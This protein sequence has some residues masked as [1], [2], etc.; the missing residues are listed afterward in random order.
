MARTKDN[1]SPA[2]AHPVFDFTAYSH[3]EALSMD[4]DIKRLMRMDAKTSDASLSDD[5]F[6][7]ALDAYQAHMERIE[8]HIC[9]VLVDVPRDWLMPDA[10]ATLDWSQPDSLGWLR[11]DKFLQLRDDMAEARRPENV[12]KNS[13]KR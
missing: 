5:E 3:K 10:P 1:E 9:R 7:A 13:A 2:E 6:E 8:A 12:A 4:L 11:H